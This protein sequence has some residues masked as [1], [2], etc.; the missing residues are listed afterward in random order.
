MP[1]LH[2]QPSSLHYDDGPPPP[3]PHLTE[4]VTLPTKPQMSHHS[5]RL[6]ESQGPSEVYSQQEFTFRNVPSGPSSTSKPDSYRPTSEYRPGDGP[7]RLHRRN[8]HQNLNPASRRPYLRARDRPRP[9]TSDRP[10]LRHQNGYHETATEVFGVT[11]GTGKYLSTEDLDDTEEEDM[12]QSSSDGEEGEIAQGE[13][14]GTQE[15]DSTEPPTKR[16]DLGRAGAD[17]ADRPKWSNPD[18]YFVLPPVDHGAGKRKD[19]VE[20]IR[21]YRKPK[22]ETLGKLTEVAENDDFISFDIESSKSDG[23]ES[24]SQSDGGV[25]IP[26]MPKAMAETGKQDGRAL[27]PSESRISESKIKQKSMDDEFLNADQATIPP[28]PPGDILLDILDSVSVS[29]TSD[30]RKRTRDSQ[31]KGRF[32]RPRFPKAPGILQNFFPERGMNPVPWLRSQGYVIANAGFRLHQ[33]VCDFFSFVRPQK[34]EEVIRQELLDRLQILVKKFDATCSV[35]CFGSFAAGLYL[36]NADMD[37]VILSKGF[38]Q[39]GDKNLCTSNKKLY[40]FGDFIKSSGIADRDA[41]DIVAHAKVPLIKFIDRLTGIRVDMS[42]E[43][44]SG[45]FAVDTFRHWKQRFPAMPALVMLIK[46]F[47]LMRKLNEVQYGG[48]GGFTVTCL[49]TSLLQNM[50]Q[51]QHGEFRPEDHLGEMLIEFLDFYGRRFDVARTGIQ[52][53]PPGL[54]DKVTPLPGHPNK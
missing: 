43:N 54:F 48:I 46:Q 36:P 24:A 31:I 34:F 50:P 33:E 53:E 51:V 40:R 35:H 8:E 7:R 42:F 1:S 45:L 10:L 22:D 47:L 3:P 25:R 16:R 15:E 29:S 11:Q 30:G 26:K 49:V 32:G 19:P 6:N 18:P 21:K 28:I 27:H 12:D 14:D 4:P 17:D 9:A 52:M 38:V 20:T 39:Y 13:L 37:V 23:A 41:V 44:D 2:P 5:K